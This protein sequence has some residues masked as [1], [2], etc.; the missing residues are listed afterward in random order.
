MSNIRPLTP[1][2]ADVAAQ[3]LAL[4]ND[5]L[6]NTRKLPARTLAELSIDE[7]EDEANYCEGM[8]DSSR[9]SICDAAELSE[10]AQTKAVRDLAADCF[11]LNS[12]HATCWRNARAEIM[13]EI[14]KRQGE[15]S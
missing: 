12:R 13:A 14:S 11:R 8:E 5:A 3:T 7:L 6:A 9:T 1:S 10:C 2:M 15:G 4:F